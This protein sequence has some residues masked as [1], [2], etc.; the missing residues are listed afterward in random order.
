MPGRDGTKPWSFP[1]VENEVKYYALLRMQL[2]PYFYS[3]FAKYHF[4]GTPPFRGMAL[5]HGF[6][7]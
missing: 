6:D 7:A 5:E 2:I 3:E 4:E 1:D